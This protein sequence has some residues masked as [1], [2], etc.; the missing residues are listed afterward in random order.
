MSI[1]ETVAFNQMLNPPK[2]FLP[3]ELA[4]LSYSAS[5]GA[6]NELIKES[7]MVL[8]YRAKME[9]MAKHIWVALQNDR[10]TSGDKISEFHKYTRLLVKQSRIFGQTH[11]HSFH[12]KLVCMLYEDRQNADQKKIRLIVSSR[13]LTGEANREAALAIETET[14]QA[15]GG[16]NAPLCSLLDTAFGSSWQESKLSS[17]LPQADFSDCLGPQVKVLE[18]LTPKDDALFTALSVLS[19]KAS[20]FVA[21]SP[22][23]GKPEFLTALFPQARGNN[24]LLIT[25]RQVSRE[26]LDLR[27]PNVSVQCF[28]DHSPA[29]GD[30]GS[31]DSESAVLHSKMYAYTVED[32]AAE[33]CE[34]HLFIG[35][36][37]YSENGLRNNAELVVHLVSRDS[38]YNFCNLL[39]NSS[40]SDCEALPDESRSQP[41]FGYPI[42]LAE[43][44]EETTEELVADICAESAND[45]LRSYF[46][47]VFREPSS[48]QYAIDYVIDVFQRV[49]GLPEEMRKDRWCSWCASLLTGGP[50]LPEELMSYETS[51]RELVTRMNQCP[52]F[53]SGQCTCGIESQEET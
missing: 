24:T 11:R 10:W 46:Y 1:F 2:G 22:F 51:L 31:N 29:A 45:I 35:S 47:S 6:L 43:D 23:L 27:S 41:P 4:V 42:P 16:Q 17:L 25:Q 49:N 28:K 26:I 50:E 12:P 20:N 32:E 34:Y 37:N 36:A 9:D 48:K 5:A 19:K 33:Q 40:L 7:G 8:S 13:N 15:S 39:R 18:F 30:D 53:E 44:I 21:V 3:V 38:R 52:F 14:F